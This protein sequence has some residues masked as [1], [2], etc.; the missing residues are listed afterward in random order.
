MYRPQDGARTVYD[1][2][3]KA[4]FYVAGS[5]PPSG[6]ISRAA[7]IT[8]ICWDGETL[9]ADT[10]LSYADTRL[11]CPKIRKLKDGRLIG[12][13]GHA[14]RSEQLGR[15]IARRCRKAE[16]FD[17]VSAIEIRRDGT[18]W[19]YEASTIPY[20]VYPPFAFGTGMCFAYTAMKVY[21]K[22][23]EQAVAVAMQCDPA[24]GGEIETLTL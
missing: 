2:N 15:L 21:R 18:A 24:T 7:V 4:T 23:A 20:Q 11:Q 8:T 1:R 3:R 16:Q 5:R 14:Q 6:Q 19:F 17:D 10:Q 12:L 22:S 13:A 9:A